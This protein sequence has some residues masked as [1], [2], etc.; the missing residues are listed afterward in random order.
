MLKYLYPSLPFLEI[1]INDSRS[2]PQVYRGMEEEIF[3]TII[4]YLKEGEVSI[5]HHSNKR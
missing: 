5:S 3:P 2:R 4:L 1:K